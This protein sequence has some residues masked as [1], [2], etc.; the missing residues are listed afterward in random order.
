MKNSKKLFFRSVKFALSNILYFYV[1]CMFYFA[2]ST[3]FF[4]LFEKQ[5]NFP[6]FF[7]IKKLFNKIIDLI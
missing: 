6:V 4:Q 7:S 5:K 2:N 1:L 3:T